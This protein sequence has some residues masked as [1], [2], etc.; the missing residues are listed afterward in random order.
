MRVTQGVGEYQIMRSKFRFWA[1]LATACAGLFTLPACTEQAPPQAALPPPPKPA[2]I[3]ARPTP[4]FGASDST[5]IPA[6]TST[7]VRQ[8]VN[9]NLNSA[10]T[11]WNL[12]SGMNVAALNCLSSDHAPILQAYSAMLQKH[13]HQFAAANTSLET[14]FRKQ[15]GSSYKRVRDSHMTR[16]YNYFAMPPARAR[17]CDAALQ[18]SQAYLAAPPADIN[19]YAAT[20][21]P[22]LEAAFEGFF[23]EF[24]AYRSNVAAWD[25]KYGAQYGA[26]QR[27]YASSGTYAAAGTQSAAVGPV[28]QGQATPATNATVIGN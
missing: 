26:S 16:V 19:H 25:A 20:A 8:T 27:S 14:Q 22:Q 4:P 21:L 6:L 2:P 28:I 9:A 24:E 10:E 12:R 5:L 17:M 23:R 18:V 3:P 15:H 13:K 11:T 1:S 7:G